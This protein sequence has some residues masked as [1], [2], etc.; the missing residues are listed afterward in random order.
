[1][2]NISI[3]ILFQVEDIGDGQRGAAKR[4]CDALGAEPLAG[5]GPIESWFMPNHGYIDG[6]DEPTRVLLTDRFPPF[7]I[8]TKIQRGHVEW[9][10]Q[11]D[12]HI[13]FDTPDGARGLITIE[14]SD[15]AQCVSITVKNDDDNELADLDVDYED[16]RLEGRDYPD[17]DDD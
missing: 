14:H 1:M 15:T 13:N 8:D 3:P 7:D 17:E 10:R 9:N 5:Y 11:N 16:F 12:I 6:H 2:S 4:L